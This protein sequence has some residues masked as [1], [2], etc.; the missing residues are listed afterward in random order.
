MRDLSVWHTPVPADHPAAALLNAAA[1][2]THCEE[3][4][5][6]ASA[7]KSSWFSVD[8]ALLAPTAAYVAATIR[9]LQRQAEQAATEE[10]ERQSG[11]LAHLSERDQES[12]RALLRAVARK[13]IHG[14]IARLRSGELALDEIDERRAARDARARAAGEEEA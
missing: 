12:V 2:R 4:F 6:Q 1:V 13:L 8:L 7:G 5:A 11:K 9:D 10:W 14:T 3:I